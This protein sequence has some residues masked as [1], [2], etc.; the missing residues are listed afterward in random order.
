MKNIITLYF[1]IFLSITS[2]SQLAVI[3]D[4]DGY[5]NL[6]ETP[7]S[8]SKILYRI[9]DSEVFSYYDI[10][11]D[12]DWIKIGVSKNKFSKICLLYTSPSPRD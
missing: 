7:D 11:D 10:D 2:F 12:S 9:P 4:N 3:Q 6:R 5:T 1:I 8:N